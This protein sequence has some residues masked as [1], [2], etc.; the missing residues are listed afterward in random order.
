MQQTQLILKTKI[1][2]LP[3]KELNSHQ[4]ATKYYICRKIFTHKVAKDK[5]H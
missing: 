5:N 4:D 3:E 2:P 1:L